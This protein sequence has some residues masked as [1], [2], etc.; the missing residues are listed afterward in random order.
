M[1]GDFRQ[2]VHG[3]SQGYRDLHNA[4][5]RPVGKPV[6]LLWC[7]RKGPP[8][9][10][11][12]ARV[13]TG[14]AKTYI[15]FNV[16]PGL[17]FMQSELP[18]VVPARFWQYTHVWWHCKQRF[19]TLHSGLNSSGQVNLYTPSNRPRAA[20]AGGRV[21]LRTKNETGVVRACEARVPYS[22]LR[23]LLQL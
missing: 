4:D 22:S 14:G 1:D 20:T 3:A 11:A 2:T 10:C 9:S 15:I 7:Q 18:H 8:K 5:P 16:Y 6:V 19:F 17:H 13:G 12:C 21:W 23:S